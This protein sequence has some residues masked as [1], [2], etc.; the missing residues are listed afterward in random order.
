MGH[1]RIKA[2]ECGCK[3]KIEDL[4]AINKRGTKRECRL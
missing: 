3:E 4:K 2:K 1:L